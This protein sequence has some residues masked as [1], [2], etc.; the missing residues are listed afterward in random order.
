MNKRVL[1]TKDR[2]IRSAANL[3]R[4]RGYHGVG[5]NDILAHANAPKGS[6]YHHF[7]DGKP[8]L[9]KAAAVWASDEMLRLIAVSFEEAKTFEDGMTTL[10]H[11]LAKLFDLAGRW[12]GCPISST[13]FEG[14]DNEDFRACAEQ[15]FNGWIAEGAEAAERLGNAPEEARRKSERMFIMVQGGWT[16]ARA[17]R[18][19]DV[20]R[21]LPRLLT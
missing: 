6:L 21:E 15:L 17:R 13:L 20:L 8:D 12:D 19:S 7:P 3:F 11:K 10:C 9:A 5:L 2:L 14:P 16:L 18:S 4:V 1:S